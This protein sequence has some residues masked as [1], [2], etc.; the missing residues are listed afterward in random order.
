M[1]SP[2]HVCPGSPRERG[3]ST[4]RLLGR[5]TVRWEG[6]AGCAPARQIQNCGAASGATTTLAA[7][8]S[9]V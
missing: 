6:A 5:A 1:T 8:L 9:V 7:F 4:C 3:R 2:R